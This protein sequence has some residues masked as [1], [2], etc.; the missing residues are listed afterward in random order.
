MHS[1]DYFVGEAFCHTSVCFTNFNTSA[2]CFLQKLLPWHIHVPHDVMLA[3]CSGLIFFLSNKPFPIVSLGQRLFLVAA[4]IS[5]LTFLSTFFLVQL[6]RPFCLD[7]DSSTWPQHSRGLSTKLPSSSAA[8]TLLMNEKLPSR[9][10]ICLARTHDVT[11]PNAPELHAQPLH[12]KRLLSLDG[13]LRTDWIKACARYRGVL[14]IASCVALTKIKK[15]ICTDPY[16]SMVYVFAPNTLYSFN[17]HKLHPPS[18][19][20]CEAMLTSASHFRVAS[21]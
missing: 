1:D 21:F 6:S 8:Q 3:E 5:W 20:E 11:T 9:T 7:R 17:I 19:R 13:Q 14:F 10:Y 2:D 18:H 15:R 4:Y 12:Q 16:Y